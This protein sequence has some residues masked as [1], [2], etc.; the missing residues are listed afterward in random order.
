MNTSPRLFAHCLACLLLF[1]LYYAATEGILMAMASAIIPA[2]LRTSGL[3]ILATLIGL[4][5]MISSLLFGWLWQFTSTE[6]AIAVFG[7]GLAAAIMISGI[8]LRSTAHE[9]I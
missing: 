8:S 7:V 5:K 9:A 3:A 6:V 4:A 2:E 1:G